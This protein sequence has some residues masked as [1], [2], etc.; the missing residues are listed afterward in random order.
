MNA[1]TDYYGN[2]LQAIADIGQHQAALEEVERLKA[3]NVRLERELKVRDLVID[4]AMT[5]IGYADLA[6][7]GN[8]APAFDNALSY[9][10]KNK[11]RSAL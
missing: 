4:R 2:P 8:I 6:L 3:E 10:I 7:E 5:I 9:L 1:E 11:A